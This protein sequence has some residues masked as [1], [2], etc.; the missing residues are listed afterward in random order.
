MEYRKSYVHSQHKG[1]LSSL[2]LLLLLV[3]FFNPFIG[4]VISFAFLPRVKTIKERSALY[5]YISLFLGMVAYTQYAPYGDVSRVYQSIIEKDIAFRNDFSSIFYTKHIV[6]DSVNQL[7]YSITGETRFISLFWIFI[8][9]FSTFLASENL[10]Q[11]Y[12]RQL[13]G[14]EFML[15]VVSIVFCFVY[16][17]QVTEIMKQG[18]STALFYYTYSCLLIGKKKRAIIVLL[19]SI[20]I[21]FSVLF[22]L[23]LLFTKYIHFIIIAVCVSLSFLLREF[24]L[25]GT[26]GEIV[27][28][29]PV[30]REIMI[31]DQLVSSVDEFSLKV[32]GFFQATS[33]FIFFNFIFYTFISV[34]ASFLNHKSIVLQSCLLMIAILNVNYFSDHNYTRLI[35]MLFPF[36]LFLFFELMKGPQNIVSRSL[37]MMLILGCFLANMRVFLGRVV[38]GENPTSYLDN[39]LFNLLAYPSFMYFI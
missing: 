26:V 31:L 1:Y 11:Y 33:S 2:P 20:N 17:T 9:Y 30:L 8:T 22:L 21:H 3:F 25:L 4:F 14:N 38:M 36:Y 19:L 39:S 32:D 29:I 13:K 16:F 37:L 28:G 27:S 5:A 7:I 35:I 6:F 34:V 18:V 12:N 24:D 23:P 10:M 15:L